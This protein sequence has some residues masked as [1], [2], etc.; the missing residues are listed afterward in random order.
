MESNDRRRANRGVI[1]EDEKIEEIGGIFFRLNCF[2]SD[3]E[4]FVLDALLNF[5]LVEGFENRK[6]WGG[7]WEFLKLLKRRS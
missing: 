6:M 5:E 7:T 4:N 1:L 2:V 3:G